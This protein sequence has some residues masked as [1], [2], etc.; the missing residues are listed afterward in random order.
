VR[1]GKSASPISIGVS[2]GL[3]SNPV[4]LITVKWE[5]FLYDGTTYDLTHLHPRTLQFE[6]P[7]EKTKPATTF[8]VDVTFG[9]H[10]FT[11][12]PPE[13]LGYDRRLRYADARHI[14][15]FDFE[16]YELSKKLPKIIEELAAR[17]CRNSGKGNFFTIEVVDKDRKPADYDIFFL[18]TK[19]SQKG[20]INL[21][22]QSAYIRER[23][24]LKSS[25]SIK[26]LYILHNVLNK[27]PIK[28]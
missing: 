26:F 10:C 4:R 19:S 3:K 20:R 14:R 2:E 16:R 23:K 22:I 27:I 1:I 8:T 12:D 17:K 6:R 24:T 11:S 13:G 25:T 5:A 9:L 21:F 28:P 18:V 7:A 15:V